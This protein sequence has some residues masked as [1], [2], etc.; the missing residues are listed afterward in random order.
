MESGLLNLT[1]LYAFVRKHHAQATQAMQ[2]NR[3]SPL[4]EEYSDICRK[5]VAGIPIMR[6]LYLW[7]FYNR[8]GFWTNIYIGKAGLKKTASLRNRIF[9]ELT[10][11]RAC[12]WREVLSTEELERVGQEIHPRMWHKYI[13]RWN[14]AFEKSGSTHIAWIALPET[15]EANIEPIEN[16]LIEAMNPTGN[17]KRTQPPEQFRDDTKRV[18]G[19]FREIIN[20]NANRKTRFPLK[21]HKDFWK[22]LG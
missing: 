17:R 6:G 16:D 13:H 22:Q 15:Y 10:A 19:R 7:G 2:I 11:E 12:I 3:H 4:G 18:F 21:F 20:A 5:K 9:K 14:N 8:N 1:E